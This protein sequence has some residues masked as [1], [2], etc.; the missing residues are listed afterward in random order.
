MNARDL[1]LVKGIGEGRPYSELVA[2][3]S[4]DQLDLVRLVLLLI[5]SAAVTARSERPPRGSADRR[6]EAARALGVLPGA[7]PEQLRRAY[8]T[9]AKRFHPDRHPAADA[10]QKA[11]LAQQFSAIDRAYR[12]LK[13]G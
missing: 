11:T 5:A 12:L 9:L 8:L 4:G 6:A 2:E 1:E 10:R 7:S 3:W 13:F